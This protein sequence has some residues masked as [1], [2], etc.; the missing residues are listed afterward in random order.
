MLSSRSNVASRTLRQQ[1]GILLLPK[2]RG[3]RIFEAK[4]TESFLN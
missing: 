2:I 1:Q 4:G 3:R